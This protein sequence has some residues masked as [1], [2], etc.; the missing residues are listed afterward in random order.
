MIEEIIAKARKE[1][2]WIYCRYQDL[3]F[4]PDDLEK[5]NKCGRF[6]WGTINWEVKDPQERV[7]ELRIAAIKA[8]TELLQF[9]SRL[10]R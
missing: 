1:G 4:S 9:K 7:K 2:K 3:W 5:Q 10:V 8:L 6:L